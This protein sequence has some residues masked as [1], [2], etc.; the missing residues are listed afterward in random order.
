MAR[1]AGPVAVARGR[2]VAIRHQVREEEGERYRPEDFAH[3]DVGETIAYN[4]GRSGRGAKV[5][6]GRTAYLYC[7]RQPDGVPE[8]GSDNGPPA[9]HAIM[10]DADSRGGS[11]GDR[12]L[13]RRAA[14]PG[15]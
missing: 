12:R 2:P 5:A 7:T 11:R 15:P 4:K 9:G 13:L 1:T 8:P 10:L 14:G 6:R 3:L